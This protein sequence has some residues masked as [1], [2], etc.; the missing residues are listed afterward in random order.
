MVEIQQGTTKLPILVTPRINGVDVT[1]TQIKNQ[2]S[3]FFV[4]DASTPIAF[5]LETRTRTGA[6]A[7]LAWDSTKSTDSI[8]FFLPLDSF[9]AILETYTIIPYWTI[10]SEKIYAQESIQL[11]VKQLHDGI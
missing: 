11:V 6:V 9:Y 5:T 1:I 4:D 2:F 3:N 10:A 7:T 8:I